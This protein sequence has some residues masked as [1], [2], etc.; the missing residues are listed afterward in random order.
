MRIKDKSF[1]KLIGNFF[2][3][4][5]PK[6]KCYSKNTIE[7]YKTSFNLFVDYMQAEKNIS[8]NLLSI[9][10]FN[11]SNINDFLNY[12]SEQRNCSASTCNQRL[13]ALRS[14]AKYIGLVDFSFS[15]VHVDLLN[16]P[17]KKSPSKKVEYLTENALK[18]LLSQPNTKQDKEQRNLFFMILMYDTAARCGELLSLKINDFV[19]DTKSPYVYLH[20]KGNKVR[21]VPIMPTTVEHL[22][23]YLSIFHNDYTRKDDCYL[24]YIKT[25]NVVHQISPDTIASFMKKYALSAQ[26]ES[27]DFPKKLHPHML[28]HTRAIHL[29]RAGMPLPLLSEFLGHSS[30]ETTRIYAYADTEM[31]RQAIE[32]ASL[33][34]L[35]DEPLIW[36][37][38]DDDTLRKLAGL[39]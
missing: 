2:Q 4:Y 20:G 12:I 23:H 15:F 10:D 8:L 25:H 19:L 29:Y 35:S 7:S 33:G 13:M 6:Q 3:I 39:R 26:N 16:V 24:F 34:I 9:D 30:L 18:L 21:T 14:F 37:L 36:D 17:I 1:I 32:K 22:K 5:L 28:R 31:K 27:I 38:A 11:K